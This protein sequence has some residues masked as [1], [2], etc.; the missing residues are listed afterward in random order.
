M[1]LTTDQLCALIFLYGYY[2]GFGEGLD[3]T[4]PIAVRVG[5][6]MNDVRY[7]FNTPYEMPIEVKSADY[8]KA[9]MLEAYPGLPNIFGPTTTVES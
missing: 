6:I 9:L 8:A 2:G 3:Q 5:K 1:S 7:S 4:N